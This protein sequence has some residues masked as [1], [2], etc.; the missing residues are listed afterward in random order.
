MSNYNCL[1]SGAATII[2]LI[3][4]ISPISVFSA[5]V[6]IDSLS[7]AQGTSV[8]TVPVNLVLSQSDLVSGLNMSISYDTTGLVF[9][10]VTTGS[11]TLS[12]NKTM[13]SHSPSGG[14]VN[15]V[16]Y[17]MTPTEG[18]NDGTIANLEFNAASAAAEGVAYELAI[19][20]CVLSD[21]DADSV[22]VTVSK[23]QVT[24]S[25]TADESEP[26]SGG[27]SGS[28]SCFISLLE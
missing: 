26:E 22:N 13:I 20:E 18:I 24:I 12:A 5:T 6:S 9:R 16:I 11:A 1:K 27:S 19:T 17:S 28:S 8:I 23:G 10:N 15:L 2:T 25:E 14:L 7:I 4:L 21:S 3:V